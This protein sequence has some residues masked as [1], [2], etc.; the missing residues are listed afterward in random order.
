LDGLEPIVASSETIK[1]DDVANI[2]PARLPSLA[3]NLALR[4]LTNWSSQLVSWAALLI[5]VRLLSPADFGLVGMSVALYVY[6]KFLGTF[7]LQMAVLRYRELSEEALAQLNTMGALLGTSAFLL[8]CLL[9]WPTALFFR[10]PRLAPVAIVTCIGLIPLGIRSVPE[11]LMNKHMRLKSISVFD[12]LRDIL[13]AVVTVSLAWLGF[14]YWALVLGNLIPDIARCV[15]ILSVQHHRYAWPRLSVIRQPLTFGMHVVGMVFSWSTYSTLDNVTAGRVLGQSALGFYGMAW[16]LANTPLEKIVSLVTTIVPA[17]LS[18]V[19]TDVSALR[20][21]LRTLSEGIALVTFPTTVGMALVAREAVPLLMGPKWSGMIAPLQV[22]S[23]YATFRALVA[24]L[25]K[26]LNMVGQAGFA[27]RVEL[28]GLVIMPT[29]FL[30]GSHWGL[31]GIALGWIYAYPLIGAALYWKTLK[32]VQ[33]TVGD[34]LKALRP[35]LDGTGAMILAIWGFHAIAR[36][37]LSPWLYLIAEIGLGA[38][39]YMAVVIL[40]HRERLMYFRN[41]TRG[42]T[43]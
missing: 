10:T 6:L 36:F 9:A 27:M 4:A 15:V 32:S 34:Y 8:A 2:A 24:L 28:T 37:T 22:L 19:Q 31:K 26:V 1:R 14:H 35:A 17:Y 41:V 11:G 3:G 30:I 12:G 23:A 39:V 29:A 42:I 18:R 25:P 5:T 7:G 20:H 33:M 43:Q 16:S 40:F 13:S 21:Y 38:L